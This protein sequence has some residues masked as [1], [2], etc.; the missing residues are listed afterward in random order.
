MFK[1]FPLLEE[2]LHILKYLLANSV[3]TKY[4]LKKVQELDILCVT[5]SQNR[6]LVNGTKPSGDILSRF[7]Y[8]FALILIPHLGT[9][10]L[11]SIVSRF[12]CRSLSSLFKELWPFEDCKMQR[13]V[14]KIT[15]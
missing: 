1:I 13:N 8:F 4:S 7:E 11:I 10:M 6:K 2:H 3:F 12:I 9:R 5:T 15:F 14:L